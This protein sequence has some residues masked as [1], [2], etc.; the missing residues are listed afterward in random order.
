MHVHVV[1]A[2]GEAKLWL[3]PDVDIAKNYRLTP[4]QLSELEA[5]VRER[6]DEIIN[7][8]RQHFPGGRDQR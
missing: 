7:A 6:K 3:E 5:V 1:C 2:D 4:K 8:W